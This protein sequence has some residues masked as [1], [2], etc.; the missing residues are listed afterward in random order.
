VIH[1]QQTMPIHLYNNSNI[2][3]SHCTE[4]PASIYNIYVTDVKSCECMTM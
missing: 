2:N 3:L 1:A 4:W